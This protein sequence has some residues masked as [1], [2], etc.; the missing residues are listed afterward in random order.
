MTSTHTHSHTHRT[1]FQLKCSQFTIE[2]ELEFT[3]DTLQP[4]LEKVKKGLGW[5]GPQLIAEPYKILLY[6]P[7]S[8]FKKHQD[9]ERSPRMFGTLIV[10]LPCKYTGAELS[11]FGP[12][13]GGGRGDGSD[14]KPTH[15]FCWSGEFETGIRFTAFYAD[16]YHCV[17]TLETRHRVV[18]NYCLRTAEPADGGATN[19][20]LDAESIKKTY[21]PDRIPPGIAMRAG[22][23]REFADALCDY[24][25]ASD[26]EEDTT[27]HFF[28]VLRKSV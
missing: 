24:F 28:A 21:F 27:P 14:E 2:N 17:S 22:M 18:L 25:N 1:G 9:T 15:K 20:L 26:N 13:D 6:T 19:A 16:C 4:L 7:G 12:Q 8:F 10:E 11:I 5:D 23:V 3:H